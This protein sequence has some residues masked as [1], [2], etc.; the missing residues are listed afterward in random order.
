[1]NPTFF[2]QVLVP[3]TVASANWIAPILALGTPIFWMLATLELCAVFT[4][5]LVKHDL[6]GL[7]EDLTASLIGIGLGYVI[8]ENSAAWGLAL[9]QTFGILG[10]EAGDG[11]GGATAPDSLMHLGLALATAI[12]SAIGYGSWL[13]MPVTSF[14]ACFVGDAVFIIFAWVAI[15][16][17]I[18]LIEVFVAVIG[19]SIFLPFGAFRFTHQLVGAWINWIIGV[20][21]QTFITFLMLAIAFPMITGWVGLLTGSFSL[22]TSSWIQSMIILTQAFVFWMVVV[23]MPKQARMMVSGTVSPFTGVGTAMGVIGAALGSAEA[24]ANTAVDAA[25]AVL[26]PG[27]FTGATQENLNKMLRST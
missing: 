1:M 22:I 15:K 20:G 3:F 25:A 26:E 23:Q 21:V 6:M 13:T 24:V 18:L 16:V 7:M 19:G 27:S 14:I 8:F 17:T 9:V 12:W 5:M 4:V 11:L 10:N 2:Q